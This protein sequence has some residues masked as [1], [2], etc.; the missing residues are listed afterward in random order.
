M[1]RPRTWIRP[2]QLEVVEVVDRIL[3]LPP[4]IDGD[5]RWES[6]RW[7]SCWRHGPARWSSRNPCARGCKALS[8]RWRSGALASRIG[9]VFQDPEH[10]FV[11]R[12]L[13]E[14]MAI[15]PKAMK[16]EGPETD[17]RI[18]RLLDRIRLTQ[19]RQANPFTLAGCGK[20]R[21]SVA[22][23]LVAAPSLLILDEPTFGQGPGTFQELVLM[24]RELTDAG[25]TVVSVTQDPDFNA[26]LGDHHVELT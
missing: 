20:R 26:A 7:P 9:A 6:P 19:L 13:A 15:G 3:Q 2:G 17:A 14:N 18:E 4:A 16:P 12:T 8:H 10:Q 1:N 23:A 21:L 11:A 24:L 5:Q 22:T 25:V